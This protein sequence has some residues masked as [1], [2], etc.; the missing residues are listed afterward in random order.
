MLASSFFSRL[1]SSTNHTPPLLPLSAS[2]QSPYTDVIPPSSSDAS[3]ALLALARQES[4]LQS[5]IQYLL[6]VQ[7]ERLLEGLGES[8]PSPS[9]GPPNGLSSP[10]SV[11]KTLGLGGARQ[12][13]KNAISSLYG[14]KAHNADLIESSLETTAEQLHNVNILQD[15]KRSLKAKLG[16]LD[17][18]PTSSTIESQEKELQA[19]DRQIYEVENKLYEMRARQR[20]LKQSVQEGRNREEARASSYRSA[21]EMAEQE[22]R[23]LVAKPPLTPL[24]GPGLKRESAKGNSR[25]TLDGKSKGGSVWNLPPKRRTLEMVSEQYKQVQSSLNSQ[26]QDIVSEQKALEDGGSTWE[27]VIEQVSRVENILMEGMQRLGKQSDTDVLK[28]DVVEILNCMDV[29]Q[30]NI[31]RELGLAEEKGWKLITVCVGAEL[32]AL[33]QGERLLR[34]SVGMVEDNEMAQHGDGSRI[35]QHTNGEGLEDLHQL[36]QETP[37]PMSRLREETDTDDEPGPDLLIS[38]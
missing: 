36:D 18:S 25:A 11:K 31:E 35:D 10:T 3:A 8:P 7:S 24:L 37:E 34:Q 28:A 29:A 13:I 27:G 26:L 4:Q 30:K 9:Q 5:H 23:H 21:L 32:E 20:M 14:L 1:T 22:E 33:R 15:K 17:A 38:R 16:E 6:D 19:L 12:E 2:P